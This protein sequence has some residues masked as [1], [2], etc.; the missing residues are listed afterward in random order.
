MSHRHGLRV[1]GPSRIGLRGHR[2]AVALAVAFVFAVPGTVWAAVTA[3]S[4]TSGRVL[5]SA[6]GHGGLRFVP[7]YRHASWTPAP[8]AATSTG[9]RF[10]AAASTNGNRLVQTV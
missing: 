1:P 5:S 10:V 7:R 2:K 3:T 8:R 9:I 4:G 6:T